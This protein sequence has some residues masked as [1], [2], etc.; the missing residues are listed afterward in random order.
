MKLYSEIWH[1]F[2]LVSKPVLSAP[3]LDQILDAIAALRGELNG[4]ALGAGSARGQ[5]GCCAVALLLV[6]DPNGRDGQGIEV[7]LAGDYQTLNIKPIRI[8][9]GYYARTA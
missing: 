4:G 7:I 6:G 8:V 2:R 1:T 3:Y 5:H 9:V